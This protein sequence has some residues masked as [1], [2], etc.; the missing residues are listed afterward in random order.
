MAR[1]TNIGAADLPS[2]A[3]GCQAW[4]GARVDEAGDPVAH[5][6]PDFASLFGITL[7]RG[8][9]ARGPDE[10][11]A[12]PDDR[13]ERDEPAAPESVP[14]P[15]VAE[16][17]RL[18]AAFAPWSLARTRAGV[19][20][21]AAG[22]V[23]DDQGH[24]ATGVERVGHAGR[25]DGESAEPTRRS[26]MQALGAF[27]GNWRASSSP[28]DALAPMRS[29]REE[30]GNPSLLSERQVMENRSVR[31]R[32]VDGAIAGVR[33]VIAVEVGGLPSRDRRALRAAADVVARESDDALLVRH[34][35]PDE[36]VWRASGV[37][38]AA[39]SGFAAAG[40]HHATVPVGRDAPDLPSGAAVLPIAHPPAV[41]ARTERAETSSA[42][43]VDTVQP[44]E[45]PLV[46]RDATGR[47]PHDADPVASPGVRLTAKAETSN[48][49]GVRP[50]GEPPDAHSSGHGTGTLIVGLNLPGSSPAAPAVDSQGAPD[51]ARRDRAIDDRQIAD[52]LIQ[53]I[54]VQVRG[55]VSEATVTLR[56]EHL[57]DVTISLRVEGSTVSAT[58]QAE[59]A[60]VRHWIESHES[61][62]R[63]D[64]SR[65]GLDLGQ[66]VVRPDDRG[67]RQ[68]A[69]RDSEPRRK[70][71]RSRAH[72]TGARFTVTV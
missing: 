43:P 62:L 46:A 42:R 6:G 59:M 58:V 23:D 10:S 4:P 47:F 65:A 22:K 13:L 66:L 52:Q 57:G 71:M 67:A 27:D 25:D 9:E 19:V 17:S 53:A 55:G 54:R 63:D 32:D 3:A 37:T 18:V 5:A 11:H 44:G 49:S 1:A 40:S 29:R 24:D 33:Q 41:V 35:R 51:A 70:G 61:M 50:E 7:A 30:V 38:R 34:D 39:A 12:P 16:A 64:L 26:G 72:E 69:A 48:G 28:L 20:T 21:I 45:L 2:P 8:G 68:H 14:S 15:L 36:L 60:A 56:P 31:P